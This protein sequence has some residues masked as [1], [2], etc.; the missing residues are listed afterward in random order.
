[1]GHCSWRTAIPQRKQCRHPLANTEHLV[2]NSR[3]KLRLFIFQY[4]CR[5]HKV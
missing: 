4:K 5:I 1:V 2:K 3:T